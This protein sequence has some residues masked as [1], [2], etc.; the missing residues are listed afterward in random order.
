MRGLYPQH[1]DYLLPGDI[2]ILREE[3]LK[4]HLSWDRSHS[5]N[6]HDN[7]HKTPQDN[8]IDDTHIP[9]DDTQTSETLH[10]DSTTQAADNSTGHHGRRRRS[11]V[12][13]SCKLSYES[14]TL[15]L[16]EYY[17]NRATTRP[18]MYKQ[19]LYKK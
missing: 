3:I 13:E 4:A 8:H 14:I 18:V 9:S 6:S 19:T 17:L 7:S 12:S 10:S 15:L 5:D 16:T 1:L 11:A 2:E